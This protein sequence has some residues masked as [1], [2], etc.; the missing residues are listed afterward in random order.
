MTTIRRLC[1][2][3]ALVLLVAPVPSLLAGDAKEAAKK[4][5]RESGLLVRLMHLM[6]P[7]FAQELNLS[8]QQQ[9]DV[10][11]LD[12]EFR[13]KRRDILIQS[14]IKIWTIIESLSA[15]DEKREP[16]PVLAIAHEVTGGLLNMRRTRAAYEQKMLA[17]FSDEQREQFTSL[18]RVDW[19]E[20]GRRRKTD[21]AVSSQQ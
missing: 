13:A 5:R 6:P 9:K 7:A 20:S 12:A 2:P 10:S 14:V 15:E 1:V 19:V 18:N 16:A 4:S 8:A 3:L 17:L 11:A 21:N